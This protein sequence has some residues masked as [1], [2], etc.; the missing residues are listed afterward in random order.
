VNDSERVEIGQEKAAGGA[1]PGQR[2]D[3]RV[4]IAIGPAM[5]AMQPF[6]AASKH[7]IRMRIRSRA[8]ANR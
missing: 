6:R 4:T 8:C 3:G 5:P 7:R 2:D 1:A